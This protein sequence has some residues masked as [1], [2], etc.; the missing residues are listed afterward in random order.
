MKRLCAIT[1]AL[2]VLA[3]SGAAFGQARTDQINSL[4]AYIPATFL[5]PRTS[6]EIYFHDLAAARQAVARTPAALLQAMLGDRLLIQAYQRLTGLGGDF[7]GAVNAGLRGE[8]TSRVG[9]G[10][11]RITAM[12]HLYELPARVLVLRLA[13]AL[14]LIAAKQTLTANGYE[15][16]QVDAWSA[17]WRGE[18]MA[19][20]P[21]AG[22]PAD[23]FSGQLGRSVRIA[24]D[25]S[26]LLYAPAWGAVEAIAEWTET[27]LADLSSVQILLEALDDERWGAASLVQA[28]IWPVPWPAI[29]PSANLT[30]GDAVSELPDVGLPSW[31]LGILADLSTGDTDY[32]VVALVYDDRAT[33]EALIEPLLAAWQGGRSSARDITFAELTGGTAQTYV[34][35]DGPAAL[36]LSI[37]QPMTDDEDNGRNLAYHALLSGYMMGDLSFLGAQSTPQ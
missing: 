36:V 6:V 1:L 27:T 34:V 26:V 22:D 30:S 19:I 20:D 14:D 2:S 21:A 5:Q 9:F 8:W 31:Q 24:S 13:D 35:G 12:L 33:A 23:P 17:F 3:S 10:P 15:A 25:G 11:D 32:T 4:L 29:D 37:E 18:D 28:M 16:R 7:G